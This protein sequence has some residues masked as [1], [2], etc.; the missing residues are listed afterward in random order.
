MREIETIVG[1]LYERKKKCISILWYVRILG[2]VHM[3]DC[4]VVVDLFTYH[5]APT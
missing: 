2:S 3:S 1:A 4:M 5:V